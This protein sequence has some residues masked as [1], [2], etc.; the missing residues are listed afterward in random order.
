[1][2][3]TPTQRNWKGIGIA[4]LVIGQVFEILVIGNPC[5]CQSL[6]LARCSKFAHSIILLTQGC[7]KTAFYSI[8]SVLVQVLV[9]FCKSVFADFLLKVSPRAADSLAGCFSSRNLGQGGMLL[10]GA[11]D[12]DPTGSDQKIYGF[13]L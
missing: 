7:Y 13:D 8:I 1:M 2:A 3:H 9:D 11:A 6:L 10:H 5:Y 12:P 4:I